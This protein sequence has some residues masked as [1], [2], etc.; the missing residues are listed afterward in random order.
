MS[1]THQSI[2]KYLLICLTILSLLLLCGCTNTPD[3][4]DLPSISHNE[5]CAMVYDYLQTQINSMSPRALLLLQLQPVLTQAQPYFRATY[6]GK[7][8]WSVSAL[9][10]DTNKYYF[11]GGLWYVYESS[12]IVQ[13]VNSK[14]TQLL[15]YWKAIQILLNNQQASPP[16][17][18]AP[19]AQDYLP[20]KPAT[21]GLR[22]FYLRQAKSY[23]DSANF[24]LN[25]AN[26]YLT[27]ANREM[28]F[29]GHV[30][31]MYSYYMR[32]YENYMESYSRDQQQASEYMMK[33]QL[34]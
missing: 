12:K 1:F 18:S 23:Q 22:E 9:G 32:Q 3:K 5:A 31:S 4:T 11:D 25:Q 2:E 14:A 24:N 28:D 34:E 29:E 16:A 19:S 6:L 30:T 33:A 15:K 13:P 27:Q 21:S 8:Q 26:H 7:G 20:Q 10:Y 17:Y